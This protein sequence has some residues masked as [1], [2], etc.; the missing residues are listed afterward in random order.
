MTRSRYFLLILILGS[1]STISPFSIDMYLPGF[2]AIARD[3]NVS[4]SQVQFSLTAYLIGISIGQLLYGPLLDRYGRKTALHRVEY[5][6]HQFGA[7]CS[8]Y[9]A[10]I[11]GAHALYAGV[12]WLCRYGGISGT[13]ARFISSA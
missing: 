4:I 6:H 11:V 3:L 9:L 5:L 12:E 1:L 13:G 8:F 7:V 10:A 2:P